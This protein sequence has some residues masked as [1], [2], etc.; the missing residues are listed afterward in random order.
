MIT[1][2]CPVSVTLTPATVSLSASQSQ[3]LTASVTGGSGN[4]SV[5]WTL[6][7]NVGTISNGLYTAPASITSQQTVTVTAT[8]VVDPLNLASA[9]ITLL[10]PV[11]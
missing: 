6:S 11:K 1:L 4:T 9:V 7:P 8:S 3:Q 2:L 5:N 10:A